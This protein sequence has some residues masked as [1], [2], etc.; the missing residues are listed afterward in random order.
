MNKLFYFWHVTQIIQAGENFF[1]LNW[2]TSTL[3]NF[4]VIEKLLFL[5]ILPNFVLARASKI[6]KGRKTFAKSVPAKISSPQV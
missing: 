2:H 5:L 4:N 3:V 1:P 6:F